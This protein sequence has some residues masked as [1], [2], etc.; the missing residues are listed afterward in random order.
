MYAI[1]SL[2]PLV[3]LYPHTTQQINHLTPTQ[4]SRTILWL[5]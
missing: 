4:S 2:Y 5:R 1:L 3:Y